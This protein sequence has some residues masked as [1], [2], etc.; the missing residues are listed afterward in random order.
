M[1][2]KNI[3]I[4]NDYNFIQGGA[5]KVA[6]VTA[7]IL[8]SLGYNVLFF[9]GVKKEDSADLNKEIKVFNI[10]NQDC[11][12]SK[13]KVKATIRGIYNRKAKAE[14]KKL[15]KTLDNTETIIH[16]HGWTKDL[17]ASFIGICKK[18]KFK[19]ILTMHD[20]FLACPNG[21]FFNYKQN[22]I[23]NL[24][25]LGIKCIFKNC[26]SRNRKFKFY[27]IIR[28]FFQNKLIKFSK[29]I[30]AFISISDFSENILKL[31]IKN[32][33]IIRVYNPTLINEKLSRAK[34]EENNFYIYIGRI[35]K[36]KGVDLLCNSANRC[37][38]SLKVVG[39]GP[40]LADLKKLYNN[41]NIEFLGWQSSEQTLN[42]L[43]KAK[44]LI[45]PSVWYEGA[46]LTIFESLSQGI[47]C[48][49]SN[50][51]AAIDFID[52]NNGIIFDYEDENW[53]QNSINQV[54]KDLKHFSE[55]AFNK[56]WNDPYDVNRYKKEIINAYLKVLIGDDKK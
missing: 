31:F 9:C 22:C 25:P 30:D 8:H 19:T 41:R 46:P 32:K 45:F 51:S 39:D 11:I 43:R 13:N 54:E 24:K 14:M 21:G 27:R 12:S 38:L 28:S 2:L 52:G 49:V 5:S 15:L 18:L 3:I 26:D 56:Y 29:K 42:Y 50:K 47:P 44:A 20:Y 40:L 53:L 34:A 35:S 16:I 48:I 37:N 33:Q 7:N 36:E 55:S 6:I 23:C 17:S 4:V 10:D 1:K